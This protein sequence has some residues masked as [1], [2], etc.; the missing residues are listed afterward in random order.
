MMDNN[1]CIQTIFMNEK[2]LIKLDINPYN[3]F[4]N[5]SLQN[6]QLFYSQILHSWQWST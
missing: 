4:E 2:V 5:Y 6:T 1:E 3:I